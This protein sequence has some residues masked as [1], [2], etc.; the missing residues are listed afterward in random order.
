MDAKAIVITA[1]PVIQAAAYA[2]GDQLGSLVTLSNAMDATKDT[3]SVL[4]LTVIDKGEQ[5]SALSVLFFSAAPTIASADNAPLSISD[6]EM[7]SK[8]LGAVSV[9]AADY[10]DVGNQTVATKAV[11]GLM[12]QSASGSTSLYCILLCEGTP[13]YTSTSDLVLKIGVVQD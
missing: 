7:A 12:L 5:S 2:A 8:F 3:G 9:E 4:S 1:T 10:L 11:V 13:T 6:D